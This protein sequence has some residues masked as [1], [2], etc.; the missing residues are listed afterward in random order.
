M[1]ERVLFGSSHVLPECTSTI[2]G[3]MPAVEQGIGLFTRG[4]TPAKTQN[5]LAIGGAPLPCA[6]A[7]RR[8]LA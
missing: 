2:I 8:A 5:V 7:L 3:A 6:G 4:M 1:L